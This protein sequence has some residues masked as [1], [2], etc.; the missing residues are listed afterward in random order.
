MEVESETTKLANTSETCQSNI[1]LPGWL[2]SWAR[3]WNT[4]ISTNSK[5]PSSHRGLSWNIQSVRHKAPHESEITQCM[6][7][8]YPITILSTM[9]AHQNCSMITYRI[10]HPKCNSKQEHVS[11]ILRTE[12]QTIGLSWQ[13][14]TQWWWY[15]WWTHDI[16]QCGDWNP[17][18]PRTLHANLL[19]SVPWL[20]A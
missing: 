15:Q 16:G 3:T 12:T 17:L 10:S 9:S 5:C 13:L 18:A 7:Y 11:L 2:W 4:S 19:H 8:E 14:K 20:M 6:T 1:V